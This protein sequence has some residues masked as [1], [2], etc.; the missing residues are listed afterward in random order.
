[1]S[2]FLGDYLSVG[3]GIEGCGRGHEDAWGHGCMMSRI[4]KFGIGV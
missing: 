4:P 3:K 2:N 1:M